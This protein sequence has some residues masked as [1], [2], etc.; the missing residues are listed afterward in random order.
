MWDSGIRAMSTHVTTPPRTGSR[1]APSPEAVALLRT[2]AGKLDVEEILDLCFAFS[3]DPLRLTVYLDVLR[4]KGGQKAQAAACL[5]CYDLA[6]QG[7]TRFEP[8]FLALMPVIESFSLDESAG[9]SPMDHLVGD[10]DYLASLWSDLQER[11]AGADRRVDSDVADMADPETSVIELDLLDDTDI[12]EIEDAL[13]VIPE[14]DDEMRREWE[15]AMTRFFDVDRGIEEMFNIGGHAI[16]MGGGFFA[17]SKADIARIEQLRDEAASLS[18]HVPE[19]RELL[20]IIHLFLA[21]HQR[22]RNLFGRRNK[23]RDQE[24]RAGLEAFA[25]L[26]QP[27]PTGAPWVVPPTAPVHAWE[28]IAELL[29]DYL[30]FLAVEAREAGSAAPDVLAEAYIASSRAQP[31]PALLS[32]DGKRRRR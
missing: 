11:I 12:L 13:G 9:A 31:P 32:P 21:A 4:G 15:A 25:A 10:S 27:P 8:E 30:G 29:L 22:A 17:E 26:P 18:A 16:S 28:K 24:L 2:E 3:R 19:A 14:G 5:V 7:E 23:K 1:K 20:P 6:R